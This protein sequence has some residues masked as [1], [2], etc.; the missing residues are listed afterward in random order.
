[1]DKTIVQVVLTPDQID[2]LGEADLSDAT[3]VVFDVLRATSTMVT[4]LAGGAAAVHPVR[5]IQEAIAKRDAL[6]GPV[7]LGGERAGDRIDGFDLGN[8]PIEYTRL[9]SGVH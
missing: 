4:A 2:R 5:T 9:P 6:G 1:M 7:L 8:S 3:C